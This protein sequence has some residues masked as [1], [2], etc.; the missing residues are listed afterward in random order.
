MVCYFK[1]LRIE[2]DY[3]DKLSLYGCLFELFYN[4]RNNHLGEIPYNLLKVDD[5]AAKELLIA[6]KVLDTESML[7]YLELPYTEIED[8]TKMR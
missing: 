8:F 5:T 6:R 7:T 4:F 3:F 1:S 2:L